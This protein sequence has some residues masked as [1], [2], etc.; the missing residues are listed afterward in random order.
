MK[1]I[2]S[3]LKIFFLNYLALIKHLCTQKILQSPFQFFDIDLGVPNTENNEES[4]RQKDNCNFLGRVSN[5]FFFEKNKNARTY[6][7][8]AK[9]N[10]KHPLYT[11]D[12]F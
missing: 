4:Q 9:T 1:Q 5:M 2:S 3:V 7:C 8:Y 10:F 12:G 11:D 6:C